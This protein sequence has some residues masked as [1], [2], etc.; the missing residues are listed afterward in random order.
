MRAAE[1]AQRGMGYVPQ[2][3]GIFARLSVADNLRMGEQIG[4]RGK[5]PDYARVHQ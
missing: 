3:R 4:G 2:G 1:R 5:A